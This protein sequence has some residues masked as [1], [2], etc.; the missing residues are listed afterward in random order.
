M[1]Y[2]DIFTLR[3]HEFWSLHLENTIFAYFWEAWFCSPANMATTSYLG[4]RDFCSIGTWLLLLFL[5]S[6]AAAL[7]KPDLCPLLLGS[8]ALALYFWG[9]CPVNFTIPAHLC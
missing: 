8:M 2:F 7:G 3:V 6:M 1:T 4:E 5:E 9:T